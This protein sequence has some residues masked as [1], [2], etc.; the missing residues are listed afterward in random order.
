MVLLTL[1][2]NNNTFL[3]TSQEVGVP[4]QTLQK[5]AA[6]GGVHT[7]VRTAAQA[8]RADLIT[9]LDEPWR[10]IESMP[11]KIADA[12]LQQTATS[13]GIAAATWPNVGVDSKGLSSK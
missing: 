7:D 2:T 5:W 9:K 4:R 3:R 8:Q 6:D 11:E 10:L 13:F 12:S 1:Q